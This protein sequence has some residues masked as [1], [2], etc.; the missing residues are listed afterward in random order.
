[1]NNNRNS[2]IVLGKSGLEH[3][4]SGTCKFQTKPR[5][6]PVAL[7]LVPPI[8]Q[9]TLPMTQSKSQVQTQAYDSV[10]EKSGTMP[11]H[12]KWENV[13]RNSYSTLNKEKITDDSGY[14]QLIFDINI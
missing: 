5:I 7:P 8:S 12:Q 14:S 3:R 2:G 4:R 9:P 6:Q 10:Y 13:K 1:M 11:Y